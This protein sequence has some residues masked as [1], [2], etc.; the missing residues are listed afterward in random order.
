MSSGAFLLG[1]GATVCRTTCSPTHVLLQADALGKSSFN[2]LECDTDR[3]ACR[4]SL[5][6]RDLAS[7]PVREEIASVYTRRGSAAL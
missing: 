2:M 6:L 5:N 4:P 1:L 3:L 7:A